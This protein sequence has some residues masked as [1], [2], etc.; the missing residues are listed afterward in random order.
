MT[1]EN[2]AADLDLDR[3]PEVVV[4][5]SLAMA[6]VDEARL[7]SM[8]L[9]DLVA[10]DP[11]WSFGSAAIVTDRGS[12]NVRLRTGGRRF[13]IEIG[14]RNVTWASGGTDSL[15][16]VVHIADSWRRGV[17]LQDFVERFPFMEHSRM[18]QALEEGNEIEVRWQILL[19]DPSQYRIHPLLR[20]AR[21]DH[22]IS[23]LSPLV[24][25][26]TL[27]RLQKVYLDKSAGEIFVDIST[28]GRY[29]V[30]SSWSE[31]KRIAD[32]IVGAVDA[33]RVLLGQAPC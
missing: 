33:I 1:S 30:T 18:A 3:Y 31:G 32:S 22:R 15:K 12:M 28:E 7:S 25:H 24:S 2:P 8:D 19:D 4:R 23:D 21:S 20:A 16:E 11:G 17:S 10:T 5:G 27:L 9:D 13:W 6:I 29:I 26:R 14:G